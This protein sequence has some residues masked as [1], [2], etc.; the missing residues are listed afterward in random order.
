[1]RGNN[2][3]GEIIIYNT[4]KGPKLDIKLD[5]QT[6]LLTQKQISKLFA[7]NVV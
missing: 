7:K 3:K 4:S 5:K 1:M 6:V 2:D